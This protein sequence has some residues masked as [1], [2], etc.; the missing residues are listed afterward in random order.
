MAAAAAAACLFV[1]T[2]RVSA[3]KPAIQT[4]T[5]PAALPGI[6]AAAIAPGAGGWT[7]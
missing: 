7:P 1:F 2:V 6:A 3:K 5:P 4:A